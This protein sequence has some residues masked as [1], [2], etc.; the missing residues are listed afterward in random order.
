MRLMMRERS[1][2]RYSRSRLGR[3]ASSSSIV[4]DRHD[5]AVPP[6]TAQ[7][8]KEYAHQHRRIE[9]DPSLVLA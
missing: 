5:P 9:N 6:L 7:S 8:A 1:L 4:S 3:L 2:T